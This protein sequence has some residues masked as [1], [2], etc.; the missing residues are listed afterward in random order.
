MAIDF[1]TGYVPV[2]PDL[3]GF[4]T[5]LNAG[6][7]KAVSSSTS[8]LRSVMGGITRTVG[9][10]VLAVGAIGIAAGAAGLKVASDMQQAEIAF[11]NMLGSADKAR[12][13]LGELS[14]FAARTPFELPD[15]RM[16][17]QRLLAMGFAA[18]DVLPTLSA[19]GDA[20]AAVGGSSADVSR[21]TTILGQIQAKGRLQAE[22][23]MQLNE[24]G[25]FSWQKL[26]DEMGVSVPAAMDK[27]TAGAVSS[28]DFMSAFMASTADNFGGMMEQQSTTLLGLFSTAK[29][30]IS[31]ALADTADSLTKPLSQAIG[32]ITDVISNLIG[33]VGPP[34]FSMLGQIAKLAAPII[35]ALS[36][37]FAVL[38]KVVAALA[39]ALKPVVIALSPI[40]GELAVALGDILLALVPLIPPLGE[41]LVA[42]APLLVLF[43]ELISEILRPIVPLL[44]GLIQGIAKVVN[45]IVQWI[46][47]STI[48]RGIL[49]FLLSPLGALIGFLSK[50]RGFWS[51]V[52]GGV[53][54]IARKVRD[55][56][57]GAFEF[58][59]DK[60]AGA[61]DWLADKISA[62]FDWIVDKVEWVVGKLEWLADHLP[63]GAIGGG[64][65]GMDLS[66]FGSLGGGAAGGV[67]TRRSLL[68]TGEGAGP[69]ALVPLAGREGEA[70]MRQIAAA[71]RS[72]SGLHVLSG[73]LDLTRNG[74][75][76]IRAIA[77]EEMDEEAA[78]VA[79][80]SRRR[81]A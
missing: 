15:V 14:D 61:W 40:I 77:R 64:V 52:W 57:V 22:E 59:T 60:I 44:A 43:A 62:V 70:A 63:G 2:R 48:I 47:Q 65:S 11:T 72:G 54:A 21:V 17:A 35:K 10:G 8:R 79:R 58:V 81:S 3:T 37:I 33:T 19:V 32:P 50:F 31:I 55:A 5:E 75:I 69:E 18:K 74:R 53:V 66:G 28:A 16:G 45:V 29:D 23:M 68:V 39:T 80:L 67:I 30:N 56:L 42:L 7:G 46:T 12:A 78:F 73:E 4:S 36:P 9:R 1:G 13:F 34:L 6:V 41:L 38:S 71:A 76:T 27:V 26:A 24:A 49:K 25:V 51:A 20:V